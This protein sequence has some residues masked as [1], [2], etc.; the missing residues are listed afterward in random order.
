MSEDD[1]APEMKDLSSTSFGYL[2]AFLL[3]GIFGLYAFTYWFPQVGVILQPLLK[4]DATVGPSLVFLSVAVGMGLCLSAVRF[5]IFEKL[6][7]KAHHFPPNLFA[8]LYKENKLTAFKAVVDEH[9][10]YHQFYGG[11]GVAVLVLFAGWF[12]EHLTFNCQ[13]VYLGIGFILVELLLGSAARVSFIRYVDR[14]TV[15]VGTPEETNPTVKK[16]HAK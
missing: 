12:F 3:P 7:C 16:E 8:S 10:R 11:C 14:G 6:L 4:A 1:S 13:L 2:I 9:Y 15:I 5:L